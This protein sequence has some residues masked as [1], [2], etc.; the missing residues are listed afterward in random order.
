MKAAYAPHGHTGQEAPGDGAVSA[1]LAQTEKG[2]PHEHE[3]GELRDMARVRERQVSPQ[4]ECGHGTKE[5]T[6]PGEPSRPKKPSQC[7]RGEEQSHT[8]DPVDEESKWGHREQETG[9][10]DR[11]PSNGDTHEGTVTPCAKETL[12]R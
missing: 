9:P 2:D 7:Q 1:R 8:V 3:H 11:D 4:P 12:W 6:P 5:T 10:C